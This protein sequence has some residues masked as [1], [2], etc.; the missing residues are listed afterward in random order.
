MRTLTKTSFLCLLP[1]LCF[2]LYPSLPPS[3]PPY[4]RSQSISEEDEHLEQL[5]QSVGGPG[6][7]GV[8][9]GESSA[10][11]QRG[12]EE[13]VRSVPCSLVALMDCFPGTMEITTRNIYFLSDPVEK[14]TNTTCEGVLLAYHGGGVGHVA[15]DT[16]VCMWLHVNYTC[17]HVCLLSFPL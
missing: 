3:L 13:V 9:R 4:L 15:M 16:S 6:S 12:K 1:R 8:D 2:S 17:N 10:S 11:Q 7:S 14:K 5:L